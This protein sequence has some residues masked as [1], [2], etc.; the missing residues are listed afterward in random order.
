MSVPFYP[1]DP[2]T[3]DIVMCEIVEIDSIMSTAVLLEYGRKPGLILHSELSR[4]KYDSIKSHT[5]IGLVCPMQII[6]IDSVK[7]YIDLSKKNLFPEDIAE[8]NTKYARAKKVELIINS[9]VQKKIPAGW[10]VKDH[11]EN[12][13]WP[14]HKKWGDCHEAMETFMRD[15]SFEE[16]FNITKPDLKEELIKQIRLRF[17]VKDFELIRFVEVQSWTNQGILD[18]KLALNAGKI[19]DKVKICQGARGAYQITIISKTEQ[20]AEDK[21]KQVIKKIIK[22]LTPGFSRCEVLNI[23]PKE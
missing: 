19:D 10:E 17:A 18:V 15:I 22:K 21:F 3:D 23:I 7:G 5:R 2:E 14:A 4:R 16:I 6:R 11:Y 1:E 9:L 8:S 13:V 20:E 12:W